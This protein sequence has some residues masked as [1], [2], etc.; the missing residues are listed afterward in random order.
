FWTGDTGM[1][2]LSTVI[3]RVLATGYSHHI[4]RLMV[5]CNF[6]MLAGIDPAAV[7][8][9]FL[10]AYEDAYEW[11]VLPNV[12]GMGLN[13]D[14]GQT[15]TKPYVASANYLNRMGD[16]CGGCQYDRTSRTGPDACPFNTLYWDFM[17]RNET[18]LKA[19]PRTGP[20]VLGV[21]R[22]AM[23]ER[24]LIQA[25]ANEFRASLPRYESSAGAMPC[26]E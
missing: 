17:I 24:A 13:A 21:G 3:R 26:E 18:R 14:G 1:S 19:N 9:W 12:I 22:I 25:K 8:H 4:E 15:A 16:F 20:A 11:V 5:I 6:C 23:D 7:A 10:A 2:C